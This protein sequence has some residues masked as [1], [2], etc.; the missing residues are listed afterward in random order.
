MDLVRAFLITRRRARQPL[1]QGGWKI[2]TT[3]RAI[4]VPLYRLDQS[5]LVSQESCSVG[6]YIHPWF[7]RL[8]ATVEL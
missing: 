5:L 3:A 8:L 4:R 2:A 7:D 1:S 6:I